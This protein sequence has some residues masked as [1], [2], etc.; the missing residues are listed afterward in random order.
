M[1]GIRRNYVR[2]NGISSTITMIV[3]IVVFSIIAGNQYLY[4]NT[5]SSIKNTEG[6]LI[7]KRVKEEGELMEPSQEVKE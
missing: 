4:G 7:S 6:R 3:V 2:N 1:V 5:L